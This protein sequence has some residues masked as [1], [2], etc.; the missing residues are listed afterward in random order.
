MSLSII[1]WLAIL[2]TSYFTM[3]EVK[4]TALCLG[5]VPFVLGESDWWAMS[6][7]VTVY[8]VQVP[9]GIL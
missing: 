3:F 9:E 6:E 1:A 2:P 8:L 7:Y 4:I 5:A